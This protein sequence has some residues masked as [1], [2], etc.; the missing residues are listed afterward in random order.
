MAEKIYHFTDPE[1]P[2]KTLIVMLKINIAL[3]IIAFFGGIFE[4]L[5]LS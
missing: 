1:K 5:V 2:A 4:Y 3:F